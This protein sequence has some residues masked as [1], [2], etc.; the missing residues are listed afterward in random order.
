MSDFSQNGIISTLHDFGTKTTSEIEKEPRARWD[1]ALATSLTEQA[2]WTPKNWDPG[3]Q[4]KRKYIFWE[5]QQILETYV[6]VDV[7]NDE[8]IFIYKKFTK[9]EKPEKVLGKH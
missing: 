3:R 6:K 7:K 2:R 8:I 9:S 1:S 4:T 5:K